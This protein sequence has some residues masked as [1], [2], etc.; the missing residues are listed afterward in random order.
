MRW[1]MAVL[2]AALIVASPDGGTHWLPVLLGAFAAWPWR[3]RVLRLLRP[4]SPGLL[5][6][7]TD[8]TLDVADVVLHFGDAVGCW[9]LGFVLVGR[10]RVWLRAARLFEVVPRLRRQ[11]TGTASALGLPMLRRA[12]TRWQLST[13][14]G[15]LA[16]TVGVLAFPA[17]APW[18]LAGVP[19]ALPARST[20][21]R[22]LRALWIIACLGLVLGAANH[23]LAAVTGSGAWILVGMLVALAARRFAR[24]RRIRGRSLVPVGP[25]R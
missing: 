5:P 18:A 10:V 11:P 23:D 8:R 6:I 4:A 14:L 3:H 17:L 25:H 9:I 12:R 21:R 15:V 2:G 13:A 20:P 7:F 22:V 1:L 16:L 24:L 19:L